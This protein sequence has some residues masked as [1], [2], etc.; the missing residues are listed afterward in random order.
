MKK[1][2]IVIW[3]LLLTNVV[4]DECSKKKE[5]FEREERAHDVV[6]SIAVASNSAYEII[7]RFVKEGETLLRECPKVYSLDRQ[8]TLRRKVKKARR[9]QYR[10]KVFTQEQVAGYAVNHPQQRVIY[11]WGKVRVS[12]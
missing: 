3:I 4:A 11:K 9:N 6:K 7:G 5:R 1:Y 10:F 8:Y 12:P 2:L